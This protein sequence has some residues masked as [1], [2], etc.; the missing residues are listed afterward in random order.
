MSDLAELRRTL[1]AIAAPDVGPYDEIQVQLQ[2]NEVR[3][4]F[5]QDHREIVN[6]THLFLPNDVL[7]IPATGE[8]KLTTG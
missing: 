4:S 1:L 7:R 3:V 6:I 8:L 2:D 5:M